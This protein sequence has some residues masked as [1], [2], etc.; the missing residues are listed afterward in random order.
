MTKQ[1]QLYA[2][3]SLWC[4]LTG[5]HTSITLSYSLGT[6]CF[7]LTGVCS[8]TSIGGQRLGACSPLQKPSTSWQNVVM[9]SWCQERMGAPSFWPSTGRSS[10]HLRSSVIHLRWSTTCW[11]CHRFQMLMA[12]QVLLLHAGWMLKD[13]GTCM[14]RPIPSAQL[15][16]LTPSVPSHLSPNLWKLTRY[17][18]P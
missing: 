14:T 10:M 8:S 17:P 2:S 7:L 3:I 18:T 15:K 5:R 9:L 1:K 13:N 16:T 4:T 6:H 11:K 12:C